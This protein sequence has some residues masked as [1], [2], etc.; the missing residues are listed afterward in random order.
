MAHELRN[1][2]QTATLVVRALKAGNIGILGA[3]GAALDRSLLGMRNLID[4]SL[5]EVRITS[6]LP[7]RLQPGRLAKLLDEVAASASLDARAVECQCTMAPVDEYLTAY[8]DP[9]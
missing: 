8:V 4:R 7:A 3:T 6:G 2:L 5:A 1:H 9:E